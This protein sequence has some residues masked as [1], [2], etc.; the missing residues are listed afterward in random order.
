MAG[1]H[2]CNP[3][4]RTRFM[5]CPLENCS[6]LST[7][8]SHEVGFDKTDEMSNPVP[9]PPP[10]DSGAVPPPPPGTPAAQPSADYGQAPYGQQPPP[11]PPGQ[12]PGYAG[13][14]AMTSAKPPRPDVKLAAI[15]TMVGSLIAIIAVYLPWVSGGEENQNG[16]GVFLTSDFTII[17]N[18]GIAVVFFAVI[19]AGLGI[20]LFFAGRVLAVAIITIVA[21]VIALLIGIGMVAMASDTS[22]FSG[23]SVGFGAILQ[24]IAPLITLAGGIIA[25]AKR[26]RWPTT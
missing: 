22:D 6:L 7:V 13:Q 18:P 19:T 15:L 4:C 20:A 26:R 14:P 21:A 23:G 10:S 5:Q 2:R 24:P 8:R 3:G 11:A 1:E 9:P 16:T 25:T 12:A 17:D